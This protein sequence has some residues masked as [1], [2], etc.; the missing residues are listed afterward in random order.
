MR[1]TSW[2]GGDGDANSSFNSDGGPPRLERSKSTQGGVGSREMDGTGGPGMRRFVGMNANASW[3]EDN[4][5]EW[6]MDEPI[7]GGGSFDATGAFLGSVDKITGEKLKYGDGLQSGDGLRSEKN[8]S[9]ST[10]CDEKS[11]SITSNGGNENDNSMTDTSENN[12]SIEDESKPNDESLIE[13]SSQKEIK[14]G[15][16]K[17]LSSNTYETDKE[18]KPNE[19]PTK[20]IPDSNYIDN[21]IIAINKQKSLTT[22]RMLEVAE[23]IEKLIMDDDQSCAES[24]EQ[25]L[26]E[27]VPKHSTVD[28]ALT[29]TDKL[30]EKDI[31]DL[32]YY[33]DPQGK[34]QGPFT[35][36]EMLEWYRAGYFDETLNVRRVCDPQFLELGGLLKACSG[37]GAIPF[38]SM[39]IIPP[40]RQNNAK[41]DINL[42][43]NAKVHPASPTKPLANLV[44]NQKILAPQPTPPTNTPGYYDMLQSQSFMNLMN[45]PPNDFRK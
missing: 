41:A 29:A 40:L 42:S 38:I 6:A 16:D 15:R 28:D 33:R 9:Q 36:T 13:S 37:P 3:D 14:T 27:R 44:H 25:L 2:R 30:K 1:S 11:E 39:P 12:N 5:P 17:Q 45:A 7:E 18:R 20:T 19:E 35:A 26:P 31:S 22:D 43:A 4:Y 23:D 24:D 8:Q 21:A 34:I 32:W 10:K